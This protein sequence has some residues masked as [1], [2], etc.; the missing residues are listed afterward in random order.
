MSRRERSREASSIGV[1]TFDEINAT[2]SQITGVS[3]LDGNVQATFDTVRQSLPAVEQLDSVLA[4]HQVAIAQLAIEY[5][6]ALIA[7]TSL[8]NAMFGSSLWSS[9]PSALFPSAA[10]EAANSFIASGDNFWSHTARAT[11]DES[12]VTW[13]I[14]GTPTN[15]Q[16]TPLVIVVVL[17]KQDLR[18]AQRIGSELLKSAM[19]NP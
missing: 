12:Q 13:F 9:P 18:L 5:C 10:N 7:N 1:R 16:S 11:D 6:N 14:A 3:E 4:S 2:M 8:R 19:N 15:W 17:E